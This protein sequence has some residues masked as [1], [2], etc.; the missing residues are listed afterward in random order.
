[1]PIV[2]AKAPFDYYSKGYEKGLTLYSNGVMIM[3]KCSDL[4]PDYFNFVKGV[5]DSSDL[6][7]N[8]SRETLQQNYQLRTIAKSLEKKIRTELA[9]LREQD[10]EKYTAFF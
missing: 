4:L 5:V 6:T 8:I 10:R 1:M 9:K 2:P 3:E 7:L